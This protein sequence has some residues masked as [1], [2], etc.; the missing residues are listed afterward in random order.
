LS[1]TDDAET[2][3]AMIAA[4]ATKEPDGVALEA[5]GRPSLTCAALLAHIRRSAAALQQLGLGRNDRVAVVLENGPELASMFLAAGSCATFAPL[6][7]RYRETEFE[8]YMSDLG[9]RALIVRAGADSPARPVARQ[10][11]IPIVEVTAHDA[12]PAGVFSLESVPDRSDDDAQLA[13]ADDVALVLHTS[14]TTS[15]P[16]IVPLTQRNVYS[17]ARNIRQSLALGSSDRCLNVMPLFHVHGLMAAVLA[18]LAAGGS[19]VCTPGFDAGSMVGW[20]RQLQPTWFTAVP[21]MHQALLAELARLQEEVDCHSLRFIRSCSSALPPRVMAELEEAFGVPV[22]EAY[23]MTEA[24]HQMTVNPLPP[25]PRKPGSV[26]VA[27]GTEVGIMDGEGNLLPPESIGEIVIRGPGVTSGY[28]SNPE[29][30]ADAFTNGWFRTGDEGRLDREGYLFITGRIKEIINRGGEKI[31]PRE[32]DEVLLGHAAVAQAVSFAMPHPELGEDLAAAVVLREGASACGDDIREYAVPH[33]ARFKLPRR[34]LVLDEVPKGP[35]GKLQRI[36]LFDK[37]R[38]MLVADYVPPAD[39]VEKFLAAVWSGMLEQDKVGGNDDFFMLGG[40]SLSAMVMIS[41][42]RAAL[43]VEI[44]LDAVYRQ[45]TVAN[46]AD[47]VRQ[48]LGA[49]GA[50][51]AAA[52]ALARVE[53]DGSVAGAPGSELHWDTLV[54]IQPEG[55]RPPLVIASFG[56]GWR[57][58]NLSRFLGDD[59]PVFSL[60]PPPT[61]DESD[62]AVGADALAERYITELRSA[63]PN[64]PYI[65]S[66]ECASGIVAFE[67]ARQL[68]AAGEE[69]A[70]LV[71]F[72]VDYP[73]PWYAP[74]SAG[75]SWLRMPRLYRRFRRMD[76][77]QKVEY[78]RRRTRAWRDKS[79]ARLFPG[80]ASALRDGTGPEDAQRIRRQLDRVGGPGRGGVWRYTPRPYDGRMALFLAEGTGIWPWQDRRLMWRRVARGGCEVHVVPGEHEQILQEPYVRTVAERIR[81]CMDRATRCR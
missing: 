22:L 55:S 17:S 40:S 80:F 24:S 75:V 77:V 30:N 67:M 13:G 2:I 63:R 52:D 50:I 60:R 4:R 23:G 31:S 35:T 34:I 27:A 43:Q 44:D 74:Y 61:F 14:G 59:Y 21:T 6:N 45:L 3:H 47:L 42:V 26:G 51:R 56:L 25:R 33:L 54:A 41:R 37:L 62:R 18:S 9:A 8:F 57:V 76:A 38:D 16:K 81:R 72:D 53:S 12:S 65:L 48:R 79:L 32:V 15:R 68:Q 7:P 49:E 64:G 70:L 36:G 1:S 19:V 20:L 69:V 46:L 10:M 11:G 39:A 5:P 29:A 66:G 78:F 71:M 58:R 73:L 28:E